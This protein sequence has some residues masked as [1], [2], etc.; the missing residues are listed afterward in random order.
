MAVD[1]SP[2]SAP[3]EG[4]VSAPITSDDPETSGAAANGLLSG[5]GASPSCS[6]SHLGLFVSSDS[7]GCCATCSSRCSGTSGF[8]DACSSTPRPRACSTRPSAVVLLVVFAASVLLTQSFL[9]IEVA[10]LSSLRAKSQ[11]IFNGFTSTVEGPPSLML[12]LHEPSR[13]IRGKRSEVVRPDSHC[14]I[15]NRL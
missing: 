8:A 14:I 1:T 7:F 3:G 2:G 10:S 5:E 6:P 15:L 13:G 9:I 4:D 11:S 12:L